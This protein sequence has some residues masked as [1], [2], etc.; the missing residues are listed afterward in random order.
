ML[1]KPDPDVLAAKMKRRLERSFPVEGG[2]GG[3][4]A[5]GSFGSGLLLLAI[6]FALGYWWG[7]H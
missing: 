5:G 2:D 4:K 1:P 6:G 7:T 3:S